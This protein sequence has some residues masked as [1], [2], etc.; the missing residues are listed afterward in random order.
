MK[1]GRFHAESGQKVVGRH[2]GPVFLLICAVYAQKSRTQGLK[3][4][5]PA[6]DEESEEQQKYEWIASLYETSMQDAYVFAKIAENG[7]EAAVSWHR[8]ENQ[9]S[10][11]DALMQEREKKGEASGA[12]KQWFF[13]RMKLDES[14]HALDI[15]NIYL[16]DI[17]QT[18]HT[19]WKCA[20]P[21]EN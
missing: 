6:H 9:E 5:V 3:K 11:L 21:M 19:G 18:S 1:K 16:A 14:I 20:M 2:I 17:P 10:F 7:K 15:R 13:V 4:Y 12:E 8:F